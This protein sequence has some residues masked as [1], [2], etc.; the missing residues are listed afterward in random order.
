MRLP[1]L[2]ALKAFEAAART[3]SFTM[4]GVEMNVSSA[5]VSQQ[6]RK[7]EAYFDRKLFFRN[8]NQLLLTDAGRDLYINAA[9]TLSQIAEFTENTLS[10]SGPRALV[11]SALPSLADRWLPAVLAEYSAAPVTV[12]I[13][14]DP[15]ELE[16]HDVDVRLSYGD[17]NYPGYWTTPLFQDHLVPMAT[18]EIAAHWEA[19]YPDLSGFRP[20]H[21]DWGPSFLQM[22]TWSD[23]CSASGVLTRFGKGITVPGGAA[24]LTLAEAGGGVALGQVELAKTALE[25]GRL[26]R[27]SDITIPMPTPYMLVVTN[28]RRR[29]ARIQAFLSLCQR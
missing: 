13:E 8:N 28:A 27:L 23:W 15:I 10:T 3:C 4:A 24:A 7:L 9:S 6:V 25:D 17:D 22:P 26:V 5:A 12:R 18:P 21:M 11:V 29:A 19:A 1:P 16:R 2:N 14:D 20:I